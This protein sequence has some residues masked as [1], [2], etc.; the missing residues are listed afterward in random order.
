MESVIFDRFLASNQDLL[1][2]A[3]LVPAPNA[4]WG[5]TLGTILGP[6]PLF[7]I[8]RPFD[9]FFY[10]FQFFTFFYRFNTS[11]KRCPSRGLNVQ[12]LKISADV[13][14]DR[15]FSHHE[16]AIATLAAQGGKCTF[17]I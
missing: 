15:L 7:W 2:R 4:L 14:D 8:L 13:Q 12:L 10:I 16:T 17:S 11:S 9:D 6:K 1:V 3:R 5:T